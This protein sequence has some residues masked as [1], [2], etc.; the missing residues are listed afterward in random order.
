M[1]SALSR[2]QLLSAAGAA[3][4]AHAAS[5][6]AQEPKRT[7]LAAAANKTHIAA[8]AKELCYCLNM[9][10]IRGQKLPVAQQVEVAADSLTIVMHDPGAGFDLARVPDPTSPENLLRE[11]GRGIF[12]MRQM[13]DEVDYSFDKGTTVRL[14]KRRR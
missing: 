12:I 13:M 8:A 2:R 4:L 9:S 6:C 7:Q 5:T 11:R 1:N 3:A 10:T 14:V